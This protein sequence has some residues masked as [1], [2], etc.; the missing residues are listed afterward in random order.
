MCSLFRPSDEFQ[1]TAINQKTCF[2]AMTRITTS[3]PS[4]YSITSN[5]VG[6]PYAR[7]VIRLK[8]C[9]QPAN[10]GPN[11]FQLSNIRHWSF[12]VDSPESHILIKFKIWMSFGPCNLFLGHKFATRS[13]P[14]GS[15]WVLAQS[16]RS[17]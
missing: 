15:C 6:N 9:Y 2:P 5:V 10:W 8:E 1:D 17:L 3:H 4:F 14:A 11:Q 7:F 16:T 13:T 12:M